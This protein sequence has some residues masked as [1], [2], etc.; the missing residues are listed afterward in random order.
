MRQVSHI[1]TAEQGAYHW[2]DRNCITTAWALYKWFRS[3]PR[4][5][6]RDAVDFYL[7]MPEVSAWAS[8]AKFGGPLAHHE[9]MIGADAY[10][11]DAC[12]PGDLVFFSAPI[13]IGN[14]TFAAKDGR[15]AMG[16]VDDGFA[17]LH[18]TPD[19]LRPVKSPFPPHT[20]LRIA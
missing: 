3:D 9:A 4:A 10:R 7:S 8:I 20:L 16:F 12:Q 19:G 13:R 15:E 1:L 5:E 18:W 17:V 2:P 6:L 11:V 14:H